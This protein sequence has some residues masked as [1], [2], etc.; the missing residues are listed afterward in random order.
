MILASQNTNIELTGYPSRT[1]SERKGIT[2]APII[3]GG[4]LDDFP[5]E[6]LVRNAWSISGPMIILNCLYT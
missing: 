6:T 4:L 3:Q 1:R 5:I 2:Q